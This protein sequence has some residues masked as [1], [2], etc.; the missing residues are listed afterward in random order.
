MSD[1]LKIQDAP[2]R[3]CRYVYIRLFSIAQVLLHRGSADRPYQ[4][5]EQAVRLGC[6]RSQIKVIDEDL[7]SHGSG[8]VSCHGFAQVTNEL[9]MWRCK[10]DSAATSRS[11]APS[12]S[13]EALDLL[14]VPERVDWLLRRIEP[15]PSANQTSAT[16]ESQHATTATGAV[17]CGAASDSTT[18]STAHSS[19]TEPSG[20]SPGRTD[21]KNGA[22]KSHPSSPSHL[23]QNQRP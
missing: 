2:R 7:S 15:G 1:H 3:R 20:Q 14:R 5:R 8:V 16:P 22:R 17:E 10:T 18:L 23:H 12:S 13:T 9:S 11:S 19:T 21:S 4:L 6:S